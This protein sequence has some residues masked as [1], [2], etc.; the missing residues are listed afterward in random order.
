MIHFVLTVLTP[1]SFLLRDGT[2]SIPLATFLREVFWAS[3]KKH[4]IFA[5]CGFI[6]CVLEKGS[7][8]DEMWID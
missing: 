8:S 5:G 6:V 1:P 7:V 2:R 3:V 4:K